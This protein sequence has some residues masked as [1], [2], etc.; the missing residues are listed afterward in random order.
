MVFEREPL[1]YALMR[2]RWLRNLLFVSAWIT[3]ALIFAW[4]L[5]LFSVVNGLKMPWPNIASWELTRWCLWIPL[6]PL[7]LKLIR[8]TSNHRGSRRRFLF[9]NAMAAILFSVV[10]LAMF[11]IVYWFVYRFLQAFELHLPFAETMARLPEI[12]RSAEF[13]PQKLFKSIFAIDFH[14]GILLYWMILVGHRAIESSRR[15]AD[16]KAQLAQAQLEALKMQLH[17]HFLFN[18]LNSIAALI[19]KDPEAADEMIGEL[20]NFLRLTL[21]SDSAAEVK[22]EEELRFLTSYL[23]IEKIR[24]QNRLKV[25]M[26]IDPATLNARV[27]N[28]ILQPLI[29]NAIRHGISQR[30]GS[31]EVEVRARRSGPRLHLQVLD[32]G[33]GLAHN[34]TEGIGLTNVRE[35]LKRLY[36][37]GYEFRI[38]NRA[39]GGVSVEIAIPLD[40]VEQG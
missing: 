15:E 40:P 5:R 17:P 33:P 38:F 37:G 24:F 14:I 21:H 12:I 4:Q 18:T 8:R 1:E 6:F 32:D 30:S 22:L 10:H 35:R 3:I 27:P 23:E 25:R 13:D 36:G 9:T 7:I 34:H 29:E 28:L 39:E 16:L 2:H 11:S 31:G 19:Q 20:G 26:E